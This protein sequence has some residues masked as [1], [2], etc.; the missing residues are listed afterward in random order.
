MK[1]PQGR[2]ARAL[3]LWQFR[4]LAGWRR[5]SR[6][7]ASPLPHTTTEAGGVVYQGKDIMAF[8]GRWQ[9][10]EIAL[11]TAA[12]AVETSTRFGVTAATT[13]QN[14]HVVRLLLGDGALRAVCDLTEG[15]ARRLAAT[16]LA[17]ADEVGDAIV[18]AVASKAQ[19]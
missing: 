8:L 17:V 1:E 11:M 9:A 12:P 10:K 15:N 18:G 3:F 14:K 4:R 16:L 2:E 7:G 6:K 5:A 13:D 19:A